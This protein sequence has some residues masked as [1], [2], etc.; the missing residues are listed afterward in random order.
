MPEEIFSLSGLSFRF[1]E[2][3][4][5]TL[6]AIS[7]SVHRGERLV[8]SGPSG[9]GKSTLLYLLNRLYPEN[10]DGLVDGEI[11]L[12]GKSANGYAPGEI[13]HRV[14]TVFQDPDSQFCMP[15]VEEELAF[16][17]ENLHTPFAEM[18][19]RITAVLEKTGLAHLRNTVI[20][21]LSGGM[22]QRV[23]TACALIMDPEVLL[24]DE[25]L[26]HLD[27]YTARQFVH[28][29]EELQQQSNLTIIAVEHR[30][31]SWES[32]FGRE[33][34]LGCDGRIVA[35]QKFMPRHPV[36]FPNRQC[37]AQPAMA[38]RAEGLSV[39]IKDKQLLAPLA[40]TVNR[41]EVVVIAG[42]NGSG[43]STLVKSLCGIYKRN[44][45][46]I[47]SDGIGY[48]PQSP[49]YLFLT[50]SVHQ[51]VAFSGASSQPELDGLM[52]SLRLEEIRDAHP[53]AI[54]HGQKRRVA[55]AAMLADK[56]PVLVMDEPTSGQDTAALLELFALIDQ[57]AKGG[58]TLLIVTHDMEFAASLA[59]SVLLIKG[60]QLTG[61]FK[62]K[63]VWSNEKLLASHH[64]LAPKG[65][66]HLAE[67][68]A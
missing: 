18:E 49:E 2:D 21:S 40:F 60:G 37:V 22:K 29:L 26:S 50:Q 39:T 67:S 25:P 7:F 6:N 13:N 34:E 62:A 46:T 35:D 33:L 31:D 66:A 64:L 9:C 42:P 53:F 56:R 55:I 23:A 63:N 16:T 28:W 57:R 51:E 30:L 27:P 47:E 58:T 3:E 15:T 10:C 43:K 32:F 45:G 11:K 1:P 61:K 24:L 54:S 19:P 12:F 17:L 68:F 8:I 5:K 36:S 59:D 52:A 38:L 20:Q 44:T 41:G 65:V 14:A 48:V 4:A